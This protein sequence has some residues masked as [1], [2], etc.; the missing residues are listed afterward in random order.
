MQEKP[1]ETPRFLEDVE[2][3][4]YQAH[5]RD[6]LRQGSD[7]IRRKK[8]DE[9]TVTVSSESASTKPPRLTAEEEKANRERKLRLKGL[10]FL[11]FKIYFS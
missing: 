11:N 3:L 9:V 4:R 2:T 10:N 8:E 1:V 6:Q 7:K 5:Q